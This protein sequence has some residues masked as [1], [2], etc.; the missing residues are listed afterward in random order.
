MSKYKSNANL[1]TE[2]IQSPSYG[3]GRHRLQMHQIM[4]ADSEIVAKD[5]Y[6]SGEDHPT[7]KIEL[8]L[9]IFDDKFQIT[10]TRKYS[11]PLGEILYPKGETTRSQKRSPQRK[12]NSIS[13]TRFSNKVVKSMGMLNASKENK[14]PATESSL[15]KN[16]KLKNNLS[17]SKNTK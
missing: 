15:T 1:D 11:N 2:K 16:Q 9:N 17:L 3:H 10:E 7:A 12:I 14:N 13:K 6:L 8:L 4:P 5:E